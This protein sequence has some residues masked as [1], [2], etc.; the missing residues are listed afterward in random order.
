MTPILLLWFAALPVMNP[1]SSA[2]TER[3]VTSQQ[4]LFTD[5]AVKEHIQNYLGR[6]NRQSASAGP[7]R[8]S[9]NGHMQRFY[10]ALGYRT[11][12][13]NRLAVARLVEVIEDSAGDG[14]IPSDYHIDEIR[15]YYENPPESPDLKA[16]ADILM[17]DAVFT[18]LSHMRSGKVYAHS[19]EP[20][21][22]IPVATPGADYDRT[23]MSAVMGSRFPE[24]VSGLRPS[25]PEYTLLRKGLA[26]YRQVAAE[27]GWSA[28][29]AGPRIS[30]TGTIDSRMPLI[31]K[32]LVITG[33]LAA[34]APQATEADVPKPVVDPPP[35]DS[36][37]VRPV[38][39]HPKIDPALVYT[40][41]L[42]EAVKSFQ[43]RHGITADGIVG[44]ETLTAMNVPV[45]ER[46]DQIR[47]NLERYRWFLN[48][49]GPNYVMVNI[50]A[51][52]VEYV[53]NNAQQWHSRVIVGKPDL[54]TPVF[55]AEIQQLVLN[56]HWVIPPGIMIKEAI[57]GTA[58]DISYLEKR[59]LAV[60]GNDGKR[61]DPAS[62]NWSQYL[63]GGFPYRLV[64]DSGDEGSLGRIKFMMPNRFMVYMHDTPSKELFDRSRRCFSHGCVRVENPFEL[65]E[66]LLKDPVKWSSTKLEEAIDTGKTRTVSIPAP[67]PV[68]FLYQTAFATDD[69]VQFRPDVYDRDGRLLK[70][71]NS[72]ASSW[73]VDSG[74]Q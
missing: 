1:D 33:D 3:A 47:I 21:W 43:K 28:I 13:T 60:V 57:P 15:K 73:Y 17:T 58:K 34:D 42:F 69:R 12:W 52:S 74:S 14:L 48:T 26:R 23:L 7:D 64:Q 44:N 63:N 18:L 9:I 54:Q 4:H 72:R 67:V 37:V 68:F 71:L 6:I 56:P 51:F 27:G 31:R 5:P 11:A 39:V 22:N 10:R 61:I 59:Q 24:I 49:R 2:P 40:S 36:T 45:K 29:P 19:I 46:I 65:A 66:L 38:V 55:K 62:I 53:L 30:K 41:V 35:A 16:R 32:R 20:D 8:A 25:S 50:P 70:V